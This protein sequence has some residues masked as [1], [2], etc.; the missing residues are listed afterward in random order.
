MESS[1]RVL[2][3]RDVQGPG[4]LPAGMQPEFLGDLSL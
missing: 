3:F 4:A 2:E 1:G